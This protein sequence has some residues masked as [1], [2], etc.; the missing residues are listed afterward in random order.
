MKICY[1]NEKEMSKNDLSLIDPCDITGWRY[2]GE[3]EVGKCSDSDKVFF[4]TGTE[5][6]LDEFKICLIWR[7]STKYVI[8]VSP[9]CPEYYFG[10]TDIQ[11]KIKSVC[12][13]IISE[14]KEIE[15]FYKNFDKFYKNFD[16][17][18]SKPINSGNQS[19]SK[20]ITWK[21]Y[22]DF[23]N[24]WDKW[25]PH[26]SYRIGWNNIYHPVISSN[27]ISSHT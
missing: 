26:T 18:L 7:N 5:A 16:K 17:S 23:T 9:N 22:D 6:W 10:T 24:E 21:N 1:I 27:I 15:K 2:L 20:K 8:L 13:E 25:Q 12:E 11:D 3:I 19:V 14:D 4:K